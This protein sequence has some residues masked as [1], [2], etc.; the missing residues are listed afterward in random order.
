MGIKD[1]TQALGL[2]TPLKFGAVVRLH[3]CLL[4]TSGVPS[5][6]E[7]ESSDQVA[8]VDDTAAGVWTVH[9]DG[10]GAKRCVGGGGCVEAIDATP[11]GGL[12]LAHTGLDLDG[13]DSTFVILAVSTGSTLADP[14]T[15]SKV[16]Y[17]LELA[18]R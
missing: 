15:L 13:S 11:T 6:V 18:T 4:I 2:Q 8:S 1:G 17:T 12:I 7:E 9:F 16:H 3:V 5:V 10:T 14:E